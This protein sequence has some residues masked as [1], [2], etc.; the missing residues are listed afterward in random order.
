VNNYRISLKRGS[1][2]QT[3][4]NSYVLLNTDIGIGEYLDKITNEEI[5][6]VLKIGMRSIDRIKKF[7]LYLTTKLVNIFS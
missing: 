2:S 1:T 7:W 6:K 3:Y 5:P 4:R